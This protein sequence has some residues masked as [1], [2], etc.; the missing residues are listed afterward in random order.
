MAD[1][2]CLSTILDQLLDNAIR[3]SPEGGCIEV[4]IRPVGEALLSDT[5]KGGVELCVRDHG[6]GIPQ[7][8]LAHLFEPFYRA[9]THLAREVNG[10][11]LGLALCKALVEVHHGRIW[12]ESRPAGGSAFH[13]WLPA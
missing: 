1:A 11:G 13:I 9:D 10:L 4:V 8:A 6:R 7:E 5:S 3:F 2:L 12:A